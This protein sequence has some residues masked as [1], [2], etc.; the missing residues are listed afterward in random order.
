M[1]TDLAELDTSEL[2][3][4]ETLKFV[5]LQANRVLEVQSVQVWVLL[6]HWGLTRRKK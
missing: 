2:L 5:L 6:S 4:L 1:C 3:R